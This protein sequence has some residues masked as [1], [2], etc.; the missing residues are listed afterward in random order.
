MSGGSYMTWSEPI[1]DLP[2]DV[3][4][5]SQ[6]KEQNFSQRDTRGRLGAQKR[7]SGCPVNTALPVIWTPEPITI[8]LSKPVCIVILS[9]ATKE[10]C[11]RDK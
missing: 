4:N 10:F 2:W 7:D 5:Y 6:G 11:F 9:L 8:S 1:R 3:S